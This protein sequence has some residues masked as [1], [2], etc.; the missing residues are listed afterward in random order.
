[1]NFFSRTKVFLITFYE[2][3]LYIDN[4]NSILEGNMANLAFTILDGRLVNDPEMRSVGDNQKVTTFSIA[5]NHTDKLEQNDMVSFFTI[6]VWDRMAEIC[7]KY[8]KKGS[9][10]TIIGNL[11]QD[12]WKDNEGK[13]HS[14]IKI[15]A[16]QVRFDNKYKKKKT[17]KVA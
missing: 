6:E 4:E 1:M 11:R 17:E 9:K 12:R 3:N 7:N 16:Q 2:K 10:V 8:L 13:I 5:V 14:R 15:I